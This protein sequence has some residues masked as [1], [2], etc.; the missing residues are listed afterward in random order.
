MVTGIWAEA[1][2]YRHEIDN[3]RHHVRSLWWVI[4]LQTLIMAGL[5]WGWH[6]APKRLTVHVPPDLSAGATLSVHEVGKASVFAFAF[7][8]FQQLNRWPE[9]GADDYP[10]AIFKLSPYLTESYRTELLES[11]ELKGQRGEL[12]HR[13]RSVQSLTRGD[14]EQA[15][16]VLD[17]RT[18]Q[19]TLNLQL[20]ETVRGMTH[21]RNGDSVTRCGWYAIPSIPNSIPGAWPWTAMSA[22]APPESR[23]RPHDPT[24]NISAAGADA[25]C[26]TTPSPKSWFGR[27]TP[28]GL[29]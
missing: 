6:Q 21:Q 25:G 4:G 19:V 24:A 16:N 27:A 14:E 8:V 7:Y 1:V 29:S 26:P 28:C 22:T 20:T 10:E 18:W 2:R 5:W 12:A 17:R 23:R 3:V 15:V 11:L 9:D 13:T